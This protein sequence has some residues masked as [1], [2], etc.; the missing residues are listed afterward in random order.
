MLKRLWFSLLFKIGVVREPKWIF[1]VGC[2]NSGTTLLA[3][4]IGKAPDI[5]ELSTEGVALTKEYCG[6]E[7]FGYNRLWYLCEDKLKFD[8]QLRE[9][10]PNKIKSDW[11]R[12]AGRGCS[13]IVEKSVVNS[14]H[15]SWLHS[16]F[17]SPYFIWIV[18]NPYAVCEGIRR[19]TLG[20]ERVGFEK[21]EPY[22]IRLCAEQ[23]VR[24]NEVIYKQVKNLSSLYVVRYEDLTADP[25]NIVR[26]I[27]KK[28]EIPVQPFTV[29]SEF[30]FHGR[31]KKVTNLNKESIEKLSKE[32][33][34]IIDEICG[35]WMVRFGY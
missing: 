32:E 34:D 22:P 15:I 30:C 7:S 6:P 29:P 18:R 20:K 4:L 5:C 28:G 13:Y 26:S 23:W 16:R 31:R 10:S 8:R 14:L 35:S 25:E 17:N 12:S 9:P 2:Y 33:I 21:G 11:I 1:V 19:R 24:S 3:H 27:L